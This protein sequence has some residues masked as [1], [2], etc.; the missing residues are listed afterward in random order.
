MAPEYIPNVVE[1]IQQYLVNGRGEEEAIAG[2]E[3]NLNT[4]GIF[5]Q[6]DSA[7]IYIAQEARKNNPEKHGLVELRRGLLK[8]FTTSKVKNRPYVPHLTIGQTALDE[9]VMMGLLGKAEKLVANA[10][11]G[12]HFNAYRLVVLQRG[13]ARSGMRIVSE[14]VLN[15]NNNKGNILQEDADNS[16]TVAME[17]EVPRNLGLNP[18]YVYS[19][20]AG[21]YIPYTP[22]GNTHP[23]VHEL[24]LATYNIFAESAIPT[25]PATSRYPSLLSAILST[26]ASVINLQEVT[27]DFLQFL[28][29]QPEI[30]KRFPYSTH[31]L[32]YGI[33]P[34]WRNCVTLS[35]YP[36]GDE[37][38]MWEF[39]DLG[40]RHKGAVIVE[41]C[42][43]ESGTRIV[44]GDG[45]E[46]EKLEGYKTK[47][48]VIANVHL[49]CG[50]SDG[51][52]AAKVTQLRLLTSYFLLRPVP[53]S[54]TENWAVC[55]D[56]NIPTSLATIQNS[57]TSKQISLETYQLLHRG[58]DENQK[59]LIPK[60]WKDTY[61]QTHSLYD[62]ADVDDVKF[63]IG[64]TNTVSG[65]TGADNSIALGPG[66]FGATFNPFTNQLAAEGVKWGANPRPQRYDRILVARSVGFNARN[67]LEVKRTGR[68]GLEGGSDHWGLYAEFTI[69]DAE[70]GHTELQTT[71][72][73]QKKWL[74][75]G[76][77]VPAEANM[78]NKTLEKYL[79]ES[80]MLPSQ[81][82]YSIREEAKEVLTLI[83]TAESQPKQ[84]RHFA[85][86]VDPLTLN[87]RLHTP[88]DGHSE[89]LEHHHDVDSIPT[90]PLLLQ[91]QRTGVPEKQAVKIIVQPVGS[92]Y[93][94][95]F[96]PSSDLDMLCASN[97]SP[98]IFWVL[99]KQRIRRHN[100]TLSKAG[101]KA[102]RVRI[103]RTVEAQ[104]GTMMEMEYIGG[105]AGNAATSEAGEME[106]AKAE[107]MT[108][109]GSEM[110]D[111]KQEA[112][113][114]QDV[115]QTESKYYRVR[116]DLQYCQV[117]E[118]VLDRLVEFFSSFRCDISF[119]IPGP[120]HALPLI[121]RCVFS[122][123]CISFQYHSILML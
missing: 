26:T 31:S 104:S 92:Y 54:C 13:A 56:F 46:G 107:A 60:I 1:N 6:K 18:V 2:L 28:L 114:A 27:D 59:G 90:N 14:I 79:Y 25:E 99:V 70:T 80:G 75:V 41:L 32:S 94:N 62:F 33:L 4:A 5:K 103:I 106:D 37:K 16:E 64:R 97:I 81:H 82:D 109:Q 91:S 21:S 57:F 85:A 87:H 95:L 76:P 47:K 20:A 88:S 55:G 7:T 121:L 51:S 100:R 67:W 9:E 74:E 45:S 66:E 105:S 48:L 40:R 35:I 58:E 72:L 93:M 118:R 110:E 111:A 71:K 112:V 30:Q 101:R 52:T 89:L 3:I 115:G 108:G 17:Q 38:G 123:D 10:D 22:R 77:K 78:T 61:D 98:R 113:T 42:V 83:L 12:I 122:L 53:K 86:V 44:A 84:E 65:N 73:G 19:A 63:D 102:G 69:H 96:T 24:T 39:V 34:S 36:L 23:K 8:L 15:Q 68:F 119:A 11:G 117:P 29:S 49:T 116:I 120:L 43:R 50:I